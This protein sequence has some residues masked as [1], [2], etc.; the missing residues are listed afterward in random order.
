MDVPKTS[1]GPA[2]FNMA[3]SSLQRLDALLKDYQTASY[4][5]DCRNDKQLSDS[6]ERIQLKLEIVKQFQVNA[7]PLLSEEQQKEVED[8]MD[9]LPPLF[10]KVWKKSGYSDGRYVLIPVSD[11]DKTLDSSMRHMSRLLQ[12]QNY[13][14]PPK[15]DKGMSVVTT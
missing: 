12:A 9:N 1:E 7:E 11:A 3:I 15:K 8:L 14:M 5:M 4:G 2:V 10:T 6:T 13:F